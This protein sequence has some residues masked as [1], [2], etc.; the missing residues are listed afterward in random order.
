VNNAGDDV[1]S[2]EW[3]PEQKL[4]PRHLGSH[5]KNLW[6]KNRK[7]SGKSISRGGQL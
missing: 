3:K 2:L 5:N 6:T 7:V 4:A 1:R